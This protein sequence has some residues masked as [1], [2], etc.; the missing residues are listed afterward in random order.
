MIKWRVDMT[1]WS[2]VH[3]GSAKNAIQD[4]FMFLDSMLTSWTSIW[5]LS[6]VGF[7]KQ[8]AV[9]LVKIITQSLG[10]K[11]WD[12]SQAVDRLQELI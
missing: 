8:W 3:L 9:I 4:S 5:A 6:L 2:N 7:F 12:T 10:V 1:P 11:N